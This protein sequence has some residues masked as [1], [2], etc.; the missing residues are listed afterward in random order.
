MVTYIDTKNQ[1]KYQVLFNKAEFVLKNADNL[2]EGINR[3]E[4]EIATLNQY[5]AYLKDLITVSS[6]ENIKS[7]FLRLPLDEEL[8][9]INANTRA[10]SVPRNFSSNGV[11]VQG[12]ETAEIIYFSIDRFFDRMDLADDDINIVIQWETKDKNKE[13]IQGIS[14]NFGKD[15]ETIPGKIIFGWPIYSELTESAT[16][17]KFSVRFFSLGELDNATGKR[18]LNYSL[19][20]LPAE[21]SVG[22]TID[23]DL[24]DRT[25]SEIDRG[26]MITNRIKNSTYNDASI[27][28][29]SAPTI[30]TPLHV[31]GENA[32]VRVVDLPAG[33]N[34]YLTLKISAHPTDQGA[35]LYKWKKYSYDPFTCEYV[36]PNSI[37]D[38]ISIAYSPV[39][40]IDESDIYYKKSLVNGVEFFE[41]VDV[42]TI[43]AKNNGEYSYDETENGFLEKDSVDSY[44]TLYKKYSTAQVNSVG[45]YTVDVGARYQTNSIDVK[46]NQDDG[47]K[48]PGPSEPII[49]TP[50]GANI[51][52]EEDATIIHL[53]ASNGAI[54]L[55]TSAVPNEAD[56]N[57]Q[58]NLSYNWNK[59]NG[60]LIVPVEE[61]L[62]SEDYSLSQDKSQLILNNLA[63]SNLDEEFVAKVTVE[64]NK[65]STSKNS[66]IYRITN[67]PQKPILKRIIN[68]HQTASDYQDENN[69]V[70]FNM[71][72]NGVYRTLSFSIEPPAQSDNLSYIWMRLNA[73]DN[74]TSDWENNSE[75]LQ[76]DLDNF[77]SD[78]F[79]D[80]PGN[81]DIPVDGVY[82]LTQLTN[83]GEV[84]DTA[85]NGPSLTFS[86][87]TPAGIYY[88]IV[89]NTLNNYRAANVTPFYSVTNN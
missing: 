71:K 67:A 66:Q 22:A 6:N 3:E 7:Y 64:R 12:D 17:I 1:A 57:A 28:M 2:P 18:P 86:D 83:L 45:I 65:V 10:I 74:I 26:Q 84:V 81:A 16:P 63:T 70:L 76:I 54:T 11:G 33:D 51:T 58:I 41:P 68:N 42:E 40:T 43:L 37:E 56:E 88:C 75:K 52:E 49:E 13:S 59:I 35:V 5:F 44:I 21:I 30:S 20:T 32:N 46:M 62:D 39:S 38:G 85:D 36:G 31:E 79:E 8:F 24:I 69:L 27:P 14:P 87:N 34:E 73:E 89:V 55:T 50:T 47:I 78:L 4:I 29:P 48:I 19:A 72:R 53:I 9:E 82:G 61:V 60:G 15:I 23:Y 25:V 77:L 80:K